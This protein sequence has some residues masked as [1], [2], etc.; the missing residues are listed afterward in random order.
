MNRVISF[1][2]DGDIRVEGEMFTEVISC[3]VV[4]LTLEQA[5]T[6][7]LHG[8]KLDEQPFAKET[9]PW[10]YSVRKNYK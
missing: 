4:L 9:S 3:G 10:L 2:G 7:E 8:W 5:R 1:T 6:A